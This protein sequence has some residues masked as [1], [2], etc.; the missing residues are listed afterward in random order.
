MDGLL[1][2]RGLTAQVRP[3]TGENNCEG[4][5][6]FV[7]LVNLLGLSKHDFTEQI[8]NWSLQHVGQG[9]TTCNTSYS[10]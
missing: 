2:L 8:G 9:F 4:G 10:R 7:L 1:A 5:I 3:F 6:A